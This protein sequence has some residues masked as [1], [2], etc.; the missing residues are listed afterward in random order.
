VDVNPGWNLTESSG[1]PYVSAGTLTK[2]VTWDN[3]TWTA[4]HVMVSISVRCKTKRLLKIKKCFDKRKSQAA[5]ERTH[6]PTSSGA[7]IM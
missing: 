4:D 2:P 6:Q 7:F 5:C 3:I 1:F